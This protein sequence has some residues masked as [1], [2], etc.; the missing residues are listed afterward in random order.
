MEGGGQ[1]MW[2]ALWP[3]QAIPDV[4]ARAAESL[5]QA[6]LGTLPLDGCCPWHSQPLCVP[7]MGEEEKGMPPHTQSFLPIF[8]SKSPV[9]WMRWIWEFSRTFH[10]LQIYVSY[11]CVLGGLDNNLDRANLPHKLIS[12]RPLHSAHQKA[13]TPGRRLCPQCE[14]KHALVPGGGAVPPWDSPLLSAAHHFSCPR[15]ALSASSPLRQRG[16]EWRRQG[17]RACYFNMYWLK[18]K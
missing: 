15:P 10:P 1:V 11:H 13:E 14:R 4:H 6:D 2:V 17:L 7:G 3:S 8:S 9:F 12:S 16:D 5:G 18:K